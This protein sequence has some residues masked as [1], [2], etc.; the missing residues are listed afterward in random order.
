[1]AASNR[2]PLHDRVFYHYEAAA[3]LIWERDGGVAMQMLASHEEFPWGVTHSG[4]VEGVQEEYHPRRDPLV[5]GLEYADNPQVQ[6]Q[7]PL[8]A[9]AE[10]HYRFRTGDTLTLSLPDGGP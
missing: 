3:R 4:R 9:G 10:E 8:A 6:V 7:H 2:L 5:S 1:M